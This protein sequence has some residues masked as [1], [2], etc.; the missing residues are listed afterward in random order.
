MPNLTPDNPGRTCRDLH[1]AEMRAKGMTTIE[2]GKQTNL[3]HQRISQII[4]D[5]EIKSIIEDTQR[6]YIA[7]APEISD[8]FLM[9]CKDEDKSIS[10]KNIAEYHKIVGISPSH[11]NNQFIQNIYND[12]SQVVVSEGIIELLKGRTVRADFEWCC[13]AQVVDISESKDDNNAR[14]TTG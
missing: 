8:R 13:D 7:E 1:I 3:T 6:K 10:T 5:D 2:I 11:A 14:N 4:N 9:L 12:N